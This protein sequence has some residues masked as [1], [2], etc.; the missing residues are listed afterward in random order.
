MI[1]KDKSIGEFAQKVTADESKARKEAELAKLSEKF[2]ADKSQTP[3]LP[4]AVIE[5][6]K[7]SKKER[8]GVKSKSEVSLSLK[9]DQPKISQFIQRCTMSKR[10][11]QS[12][13]E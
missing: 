3:K 2:R 4:D 13:R 9:S 6:K 12:T 8:K 5:S 11:E 10:T 7:E 1:R